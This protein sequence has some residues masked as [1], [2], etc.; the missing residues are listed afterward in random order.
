ML[1]LFQA[2]FFTFTLLLDGNVLLSD[3]YP[4][5]SISLFTD[6]DENDH[7]VGSFIEGCYKGDDVSDAMPDIPEGDEWTDWTDYYYIMMVDC[8]ISGD[9]LPMTHEIMG[10]KSYK[11]ILYRKQGVEADIYKKL[12]EKAFFSFIFFCFF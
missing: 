5:S 2:K 9:A 6:E 7:S 11:G 8:T 3:K 10:G 12:Q 1:F 4:L